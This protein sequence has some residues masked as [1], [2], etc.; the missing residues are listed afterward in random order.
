[1]ARKPLTDRQLRWIYLAMLV[2][3]PFYIGFGE[4]A[5]KPSAE[6][7]WETWLVVGLALWAAYSGFRMYRIVLR[8]AA[9]RPEAER[10]KARGVAQLARLA[11]AEAIVLWGYV[12]RIVVHGPTWVAFGLYGL[13]IFL[14]IAWR[15]RKELPAVDRSLGLE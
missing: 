14:L 4:W 2:A 13:G 15:P 1:M 12:A 9:T 10:V 11:C 3:V 5:E 7:G 6:T 8:R